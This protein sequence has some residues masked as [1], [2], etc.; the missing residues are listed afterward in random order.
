M[1]I[2]VGGAE[3]HHV[4]FPAEGD[5]SSTLGRR[6]LAGVGPVGSVRRL[7]HH[8]DAVRGECGCQAGAGVGADRRDR[9]RTD[10]PPRRRTVTGSE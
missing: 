5:G 9:R 7:D 2:G 4:R 3:R 6:A 10:E 1:A 8:I